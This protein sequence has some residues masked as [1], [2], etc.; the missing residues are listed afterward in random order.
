MI[1][2]LMNPLMPRTMNL[3]N[4]MIVNNQC[5]SYLSFSDDV[6][7]YLPALEHIRKHLPISIS[8]APTPCLVLEMVHVCP[9]HP[10]FQG[11]LDFEDVLDVMKHRVEMT[12]HQPQVTTSPSTVS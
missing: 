11:I 2:I 8:S 3:P 10:S 1:S 5:L 12:R 7:S 9:T 6:A 4:T